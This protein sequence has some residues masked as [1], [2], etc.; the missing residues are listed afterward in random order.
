M[1]AM[2]FLMKT[3]LRLA[4][5]MTLHVLANKSYARHEHLRHSTALGGNE[6]N[7]PGIRSLVIDEAVSASARSARQRPDKRTQVQKR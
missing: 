2:P 1:G 5:E 4:T 3:L 7:Q 6:G